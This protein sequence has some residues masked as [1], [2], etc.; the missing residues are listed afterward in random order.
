MT[1]LNTGNGSETTLSSYPLS[2]HSGQARGA[3]KTRKTK[4]TFR[5]LQK[6]DRE[7]WHQSRHI[8]T[9]NIL[10]NKKACPLAPHKQVIVQY[11]IW[12]TVHGTAFLNVMIMVRKNRYACT[13]NVHNGSYKTGLQFSFCVFVCVPFTP[14]IHDRLS[15]ECQR[16]RRLFQLA[17]PALE[18]PLTV[19]IACVWDP[20]QAY[21][22][23][24]SSVITARYSHPGS[25]THCFHLYYFSHSFSLSLFQSLHLNHLALHANIVLSTLVPVLFFESQTLQLS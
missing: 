20:S 13:Q 16:N 2:L 1:G 17:G 15:E 10:F 3:W 11:T 5:S 22:L 21:S 23:G 9:T 6:G 19:K 12:Q 7:Q 4:I 8:I 18:S 14:L 24:N 25:Y